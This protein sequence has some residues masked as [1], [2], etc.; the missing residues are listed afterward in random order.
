M[1][2]CGL[3]GVKSKRLGG[4]TS[5]RSWLSVLLCALCGSPSSNALLCTATMALPLKEGG[6]RGERAGRR[7]IARGVGVG[8]RYGSDAGGKACREP[9]SPTSGPCAHSSDRRLLVPVSRTSR[10]HLERGATSPT[11][12]RVPTRGEASEA[13]RKQLWGDFGARRVRR[14]QLSG[15]CEKRVSGNFG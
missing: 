12:S 13:S 4:G 1:L 2:S 7:A 8:L 11:L 6:G 5:R 10:S 14:G 9:S 3:L 15:A